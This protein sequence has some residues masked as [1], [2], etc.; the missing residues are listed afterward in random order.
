MEKLIK[1]VE[2]IQDRKNGEML[3]M[4][5]RKTPVKFGT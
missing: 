3:E 2:E 5:V 4:M 1:E